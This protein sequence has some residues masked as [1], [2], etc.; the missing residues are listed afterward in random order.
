MRL[1]GDRTFQLVRR[2]RDAAA[3]VDYLTC[4]TTDLEKTGRLQRVVV[5]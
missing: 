2:Y 4:R 3:I 1:F 5:L